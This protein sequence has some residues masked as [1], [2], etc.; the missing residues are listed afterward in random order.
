M[1]ITKERLAILNNIKNTNA[2]VNLID[3]DKGTK[4]EVKLPLEIKPD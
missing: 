4:V 2:Q 3:L 1:S